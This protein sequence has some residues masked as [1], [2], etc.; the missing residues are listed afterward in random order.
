M[1]RFALIVLPAALCAGMVCIQTAAAQSAPAQSAASIV[2]ASRDRIDAETVSSR[3]RMVI[4]AKNGSTSERVIDQYSKDDAR[5]NDRLMIVFQQPAAVRG[6]RFLTLEKAAGSK[7]QW[8]YLPSLGKVRRI[9]ASEG[10]SSFMGTDMSYDDLNAQSRRSDEDTHTLLREE[11]YN[12]ASC[13][14]IQS[15]PKDSA[16]QYGKMI[17]WIDKTTLVNYKIEMY[18]RRG[19]LVKLME[20]SGFHAV[21][22]YLT[23]AEI[24]VST[25]VAGTSTTI[26][27][28]II[29]YGDPVPEGV[30]TTAYL[31]T[32]RVR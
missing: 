28:D 3:S 13:Y 31:E 24:K 21:Q 15:V 27:T 14:V 30:F 29:K 5:G 4:T 7:D 18:D 10:S 32:G 16:Y 12:G 1:K 6:T 25:L 8:I 20:S 19:T 11:P 17:L 22:G 26:H 2:Q 9:A 23:P